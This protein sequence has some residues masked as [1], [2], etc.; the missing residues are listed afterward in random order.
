MKGKGI[1]IS[2]VE[3]GKVIRKKR[4]HDHRWRY[5]IVIS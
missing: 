1:V 3:K 2:S 5:G 4:K